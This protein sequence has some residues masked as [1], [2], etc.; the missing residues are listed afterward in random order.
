MIKIA[1]VDDHPAVRLGL[2]ELFSQASGFHVVAE[3]GS[4]RE[5]VELAR[6]VDI[7]VLVLDVAMPGRTGLDVIPSLRAIAP[8]M[9]VLVFSGHRDALFAIGSIRQGATGYISKDCEPMQLLD[10]V[11][12]VADGRP[13]MTP[14]V[15]EIL[16]GSVVAT[17]DATNQS[18]PH[19]LLSAREIQIFVR[20]AKGQCNA[21]I[22]QSL[23][24][25][26]KTISRHRTR[27][28]RK[29]KM[30]TNSQLT[31]YAVRI[32]ILG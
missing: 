27:L 32:G 15:R 12:A 29:M 11:R 19:L 3:A 25:S 13:Y 18:A 6:K 23:S 31:S 26:P 7:D 2:C 22:G 20:L 21:D 8:D 28:M 16:A 17:C 9:A 10:A 14:E 30:S 5:A 4:G 24:L 1:L